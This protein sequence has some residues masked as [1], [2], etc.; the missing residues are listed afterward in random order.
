MA[1]IVDTRPQLDS[2]TELIQLTLHDTAAWSRQL[3]LS[4]PQMAVLFAVSS[5]VESD[6]A[7]ITEFP[8]PPGLRVDT[9]A[10]LAALADFA[11]SPPAA[12]PVAAVHSA[13]Q[14]AEQCRVLANLLQAVST[15]PKHPLFL[16][17]MRSGAA[18]AALAASFRT[19]G[20]L[21]GDEYVFNGE[22][23]VSSSCESLD[24]ASFGVAGAKMAGSPAQLRLAARALAARPSA[25]L[26]D[27]SNA[28]LRSALERRAAS[29]DVRGLA[30]AAARSSSTAAVAIPAA[31]R[32]YFS[33]D[34][35]F[36]SDMAVQSLLRPRE[37]E[38][39]L[40][41]LPATAA[42]LD[43]VRAAATAMEA[44]RTGGEVTLPPLVL[45]DAMAFV[46]TRTTVAGRGAQLT[47]LRCLLAAPDAHP[48]AVARPSTVLRDATDADVAAGGAHGSAT[49]FMVVEVRLP[50]WS[51]APAGMPVPAPLADLPWMPIPRAWLV[52]RREWHKPFVS[53]PAPGVSEASFTVDRR[54]EGQRHTLDKKAD[55]AGPFTGFNGVCYRKPREPRQGASRSSPAARRGGLALPDMTLL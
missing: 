13:A 2:G 14:S 3:P 7:A 38:S 23:T 24:L 1:T 43:G 36:S 19:E 45:P 33:P 44:E 11:G 55:A 37:G 5:V 49:G 42:V 50:L 34:L 8:C 29:I 54:T 40:A 6:H 31:S 17:L 28:Q 18:V 48:L 21:P 41:P 39:A 22:L 10:L 52:P 46:G 4:L 12:A 20:E 32:V 51:A 35:L 30:A 25:C 53:T 15:A 27:V 9:V 26:G 16:A 47:Q